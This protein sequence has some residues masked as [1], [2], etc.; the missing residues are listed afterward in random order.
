[1]QS[2]SSASLRATSCRRFSSGKAAP[3]HPIHFVS[4]SSLGS[5]SSAATSPPEDLVMRSFSTVTGKPLETL[6]SV[7]GIVIRGVVVVAHPS[8]FLAGGRPVANGGS[9]LLR[10]PRAQPSLTSETNHQNQEKRNG[11]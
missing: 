4:Y 1:M 9:C 8:N 2:Y 3:G 5:P 6:M 10:M 7:L 11:N